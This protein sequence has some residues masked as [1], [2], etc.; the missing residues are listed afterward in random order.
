MSHQ[1]GVSKSGYDGC[2]TYVSLTVL[3][4]DAHRQQTTAQ[5]MKF[6]GADRPR[7]EMRFVR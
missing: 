1:M 5:E 3:L 2:I 7:P 6:T 4:S